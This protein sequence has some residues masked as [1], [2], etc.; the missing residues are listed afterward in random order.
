MAK[1]KE[2]EMQRRARS[3]FSYNGKRYEATGA[4]KKE[5]DMNAALMLDKL[6]RGEIGISENMTVK[7]WAAEWLETYKKPSV[8]DKTYKDYKLQI[9][10]HI[11]PAIGSYRV[12]EVKD[13]H[14]QKILNSRVGMSLST[15]RRLKLTI[16]SLFAQAKRS[17]LIMHDPSEYLIMPKTHEGTH[18]SIT[19]FEREHFLKAAATHHAGLMYKTMLYCGLRTGEAAALSWNEVDFNAKVLHVRHAMES[20]TGDMKEPKTAAGI[21]DVPIPDAL[22]PEL[23]E[24]YDPARQ[25][26]PV[27]TQQTTGKRHTETSRMKAWN[28]LKK[29]IDISMG[30]K[31]GKVKAKDGK[32]RMTKILSV[33]APD[34]V[35]Y[36]LRHTYCTDLQNAGVPINVAKYL[37]GHTLLEMTARIYTHTDKAALDDAAERINGRPPDHATA[38]PASLESPLRIAE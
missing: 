21:R 15:V 13:I 7:R 11:T 30:A 3:T 17:R 18:R 4:D 31:Y 32:M 2:T 38:T 33:V 6:K 10:N 23:R 37:M 29:E 1:T 25:F 8:T 28:S 22:L 34:F 24:A 36:C 16:R 12:S 20:G 9:D 26:G 14:L 35:P 5:A 19:Q 27:F